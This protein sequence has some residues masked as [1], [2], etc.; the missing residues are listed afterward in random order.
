[1]MPALAVALAC[2]LASLATVSWL[3]PRAP[4]LGLVQ[5]P[6][7]RASHVVPTPTGGGI[8][9]MCGGAVAGL[10]ASISGGWIWAMCTVLALVIGAVGLVD[11]LR[12]LNAATRLVLQ[13]AL[14]AVLFALVP[15]LS[16]V[17]AGLPFPAAAGIALAAIMAGV[18]WLNLFNF[19]D[20][21]D[22]LAATQGAVIL[23]AAALQILLRDPTAAAAQYALGMCAALVG[24]AVF[25]WPPAR[26]FMGD[27][28]SY[29]TGF[30]LLVLASATSASGTLS[31]AFW[32]VLA[33]M[34]V[35]DATVTLLR[36]AMRGEAIFEAHRSHAYQRLALRFG[37]HRPVTVLYL[38]YEIL[39]LVPLGLFVEGHP[40][41][42]VP[43][44]VLAYLPPVL[45]VVLAGAGLRDD[46]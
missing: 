33:A 24:F 1:M 28:G 43:V 8:G 11:D 45:F 36:R 30:A 10:A 32:I 21:I 7:A 17:L 20:G 27:A 31:P 34:L 15:G 16:S 46:A 26:I 44:L 19:M 38:S 39:C 29:F 35:S 42:A 4:R 13:T 18:W 12:N 41:L 2:G 22:G 40:D 3:L 25:N 5:A 23:A 14:V 9:I 6:N 37:R